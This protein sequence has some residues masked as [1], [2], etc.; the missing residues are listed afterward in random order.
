MRSDVG[1][2]VSAPD[3]SG[4]WRELESEWDGRYLVFGLD[5]GGSFAVIAAEK[6]NSALLW[7][8]AG[9]AALLLAVLAGRFYARR[10]RKNAEQNN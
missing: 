3:G 5:N 2:A 8:A 9:G 7:A 10:K 6:H 1:A 4:G